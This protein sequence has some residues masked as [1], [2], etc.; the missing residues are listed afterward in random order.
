MNNPLKILFVE[1]NEVHQNTFKEAVDVF[2]D[3]S[4]DLKVEYEI[5]EYLGETLSKIDDS[6]DG[7]IIDLRLDPVDNEDESGNDI[8]NILYDDEFL[9]IPIIFVTAFPSSVNEHPSV[10]DVRG[11]GKGNYL[12]D[13]QLFRQIR[14]IGITHIL[15]RT[16][17]I[18]QH[19]REVLF[20]NI[21]PQRDTWI[22]YGETYKDT[23]PKRIERALLRYT[24]NHLFQ[25]LEE[26]SERCFPE[27]FYLYPP[28]TDKIT[29]GSVVKEKTTNQQFV[30]LSPACDLV[31]RK[32]GEFKTDDIL[33]VEIEKEMEIVNIALNGITRSQKKKDKLK[34]IANNN[35]RNYYHWLPPAYTFDGGFL[36]FRKLRTPNKTMFS[37]K[38]EEPSI[39]ISPFFV[40]DI[41]SRFSSFY[42]RQ[43]QP[44]IDSANFV[45]RYTT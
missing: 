41:V 6:Y 32:S 42:A 11:H 9:K 45:N 19:L 39:Q 18:E 7:A 25:H 40:K 12:S 10:I 37:E 20:K 1:D 36:N 43:G 44:D 35:Y 31:I 15:G 30:V 14:D 22:A 4:H 29:T 27:E 24:L 28:V 34:D 38:Y 21:L 3:Q 17:L 13:L 33:L 2:N 23:D 8:V 26:D 16:G 5:A